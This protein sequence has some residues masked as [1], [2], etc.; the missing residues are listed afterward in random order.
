MSSLVSAYVGKPWAPGADGPCAF[1]CWGLVRDVF[2][3]QRA[4]DLPIVETGSADQVL[5]ANV[6]AIKQAAAVSGFRPVHGDL[7]PR[8]FDVVVFDGAGE[9]HVGVVVRANRRLNVLHSSHACGV[10]CEPWQH[11]IEGRAFQLWRQ[12]S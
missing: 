10:V 11:A 9:L 7:S 2:R 8:E 1:N 6:S 4:V 3:T 12:Q 5:A